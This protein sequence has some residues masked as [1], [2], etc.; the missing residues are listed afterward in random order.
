MPLSFFRFMANLEQSGSRVSDTWSVKLTFSLIQGFH[1]VREVRESREFVRGSW[2]VREIRDFLE[3]VR[4]ENFYPCNFLTSIK[5]H[6][7]AEMYVVKLY[8]RI[9][10]WYYLHL[11]LR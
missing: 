7:H 4:E 9:S 8:T 1:S 10:S 11:V 6:L 5:N 3:K 2:K